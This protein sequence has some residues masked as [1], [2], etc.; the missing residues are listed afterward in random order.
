M[1]R[2]RPHCLCVES[3]YQHFCRVDFCVCTDGR[4]DQVHHRIC[5][6]E[7]GSMAAEYRGSGKIIKNPFLPAFSF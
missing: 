4:L 6:G 7:K 1:V 2:E 5:F 3:I